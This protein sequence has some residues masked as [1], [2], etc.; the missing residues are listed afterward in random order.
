MPSERPYFNKVLITGGAGFIGCNFVRLLLTDRLAFSANEVLVVDSLT[1]AANLSSIQDFIDSERIKFV[2]G[3][4]VDFSMLLDISVGTNLIVNFAAESHVDR[5]IMDSSQFILSNILGV[6]NLLNAARQNN[7]EMFIQVSTDEVYGS[8]ESGSWDESFPLQPNSPYSASKA[9]AELIS[10]A[11]RNT[12][13]QDI[14]I[15]RC[16]NNYGPF[17]NQEKFIPTC[18]NRLKSNQKIPIYGSGSQMR[19][20]IHVEDHSIGIGLVIANGKSGEI[21]NIGSG[22]EVT[23][24]ELALTIASHLNKGKEVIDFVED[25]KGHDF[26][27][28]LDFRKIKEIGFAPTKNLQNEIPKLVSWYEHS[29]TQS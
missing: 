10:T 20:W 7:V 4:I 15:T 5:S 19:E 8:I 1:Y 9:A 13:G 18:I 3:D 21:Y 2:H 26:R 14:R 29:G 25:R 27:Y 23:N 22:E 17:Q 11:H 6:D 24:L 28:S 12:H 16:C